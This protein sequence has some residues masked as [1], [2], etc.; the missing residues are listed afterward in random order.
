MTNFDEG[1]QYQQAGDLRRAEQVY[2]RLLQTDHRNARVWFELGRL[3]ME[4]HRVAEAVPHFRQALELAPRDTEGYFHLG[5]ALLQLQQWSEAQAPYRKCLE[6]KP[7]HAEAL[8]NLGFAVG[9]LQRYTEAEEYY[10]KALRLK[11]DLA[12]IHHNLGNTLREQRKMD[13]ALVCYHEAL[14][15]RPDYAK[16]E[17]NLGVALVSLGLVDEAVERLRRGVRL[18]PDFAEAHSSLGAALCAQGRLDEALAEYET[19]IRLKPDYPD[20]HWNRSLARLLLGDFE[21]GWPEYEWRWRCKGQVPA[22]NFSQPRWDGSPLLGRTLLLFAE[23]GLGDTLQFI[24]YAPLIQAQGGRVVLQCQRSLVPILSSLAGVNQ[25]IAQVDPPPAFDAQAPLM[26]LPAILGTT[27]ATV[28][29]GVP[30]LSADPDLMTHWR[31]QLAPLRGFRVAISWQGSPRHPWDRH[32]SCKLA[33]FEPLGRIDGVRLISLQKGPGSE[34]L[35]ELAG[36]FPVTSLGTQLDETSGAFMDT[37]AVLANVD[38]LV[39]V[40]TAIAHL[41]GAMGVRTWLALH[42]TPDYRWM[43]DRDDSPWY[44]SMRLFRQQAIGDWDGVFGRIAVELAAVSPAT[45]SMAN[46]RNEL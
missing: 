12:E 41:A 13:E 46:Q 16:A 31:R 18:R 22:P 1:W 15:L 23:Q 14:R 39:T 37:A 34:Q 35:E 45:K 43:L 21:R 33:N 28:P 4:E 44:P 27:L 29:A 8:V 3:M 38:L 5:N 42:L 24:R 40:D 11:P 20:V 30:Y 6:L 19:A 2:R 7:D 32:R 10:R 9:E 36:R 26:S 25:L 17:I